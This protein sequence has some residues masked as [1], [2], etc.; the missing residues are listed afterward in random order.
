MTNK[1]T[2]NMGPCSKQTMPIFLYA[3][4]FSFK[5]FCKIIKSAFIEW[6]PRMATRKEMLMYCLQDPDMMAEYGDDLGLTEL[7][8][9]GPEFLML[10]PNE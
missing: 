3:F 8:N 6:R 10:H 9:N 2:V 1:Y 5:V 7:L 4:Y